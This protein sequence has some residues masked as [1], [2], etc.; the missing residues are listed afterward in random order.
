MVTCWPALAVVG[1]SES[2]TGGRFAG[3]PWSVTALPPP[4]QVALACRAAAVAPGGAVTV[5][6]TDFDAPAA[7]GPSRA[8]PAGV[9]VQPAGALSET[10]APVI[11]PGPALARVAVTVALPVSGVAGSSESETG[12]A[13]ARVPAPPP[14]CEI[15]SGKRVETG[16]V[17]T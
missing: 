8:G 1:S 13:P 12:A 2:I 5:N 15:V 10:A 11:A 3:G 6:A 9:T 4:S 7:P 14:I 16:P 17:R